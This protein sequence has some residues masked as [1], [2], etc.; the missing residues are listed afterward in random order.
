M[1]T[2]TNLGAALIGSW[3]AGVGLTCASNAAN[4]AD[5]RHGEAAFVRQCAICHTVDKGAPNR[6]GPNLF[7]IVDRRAGTVPG[8]HY[9][10]AFKDA[11]SWD[12]NVDA[13]R[14]WIS[15]PKQMVPRSPMSVFQGVSDCDRDDIIAY[16]ATR[17]DVHESA[18]RV[19]RRP[20]LGS[21]ALVARLAAQLTATTV[22]KGISAATRSVEL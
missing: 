9:S 4:A 7:G 1:L 18:Y 16:L 20:L 3:L 6:F 22:S 10:A 14:G 2:I 17:K 21:I 15:A 13:R 5:V 12:W 8:F 11:V 19:C